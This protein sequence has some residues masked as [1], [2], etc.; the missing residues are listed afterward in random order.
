MLTNIIGQE[1]LKTYLSN[2]IKSNNVSYGYIIEGQKF[3]GKSYIA[4]EFATE[5]TNY[6]RIILPQETKELSI[7]DIRALKEDAYTYTYNGT[8]KVYIIPNAD[9]MNV[10]SQNAFLK[11]LEEPPQDCIFI[12]LVE[13]RQ[14]L[15]ETIRSRC[16]LLTLSPYSD[17]EII[18]YLKSKGIS[19]IDMDIV[20]LCFGTLKYEHLQSEEFK[21]I[22]ELAFK[23]VLNLHTLHNARVFAILK[24][25]KNLKNSVEE[26]L[27]IFLTW[28][29]DL[30]VYKLT[31]DEDLLSFQHYAKDIVNIS[32]KYENEQILN[33]IDKIQFTKL[34]LKYNCNFDMSIDTLLLYMK[35]VI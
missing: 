15:L 20:K 17:K 7:E 22:K 9:N 12:L 21:P 16:V 14:N 11:L 18:A 28:Y 35:G 29:R 31:K 27:D 33:I 32:E 6:V 25:I 4:N 26:L 19:D 13:N 1:K 24:H 3:M 30:Y 10:P 23:I 5:L 34:K 2:E 8:K